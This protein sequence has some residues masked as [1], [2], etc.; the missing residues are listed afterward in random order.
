M[1]PS[2]TSTYYAIGGDAVRLSTQSDT[3]R[4]AYITSDPCRRCANIDGLV[5]TAA[6]PTRHG[7]SSVRS[8]RTWAS[9]ICIRI[10]RGIAIPC[11]ASLRRRLWLMH[12]IRGYWG[13]PPLLLVRPSR[14]ASVTGR[15]ASGR[16][17][18]LFR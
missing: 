12:Q 16:V 17:G 15:T 4:E 14:R 5:Q 1:P 2:P 7:S 6:Y 9:P 3:A 18:A 13:Y 8:S 10:A 11:C